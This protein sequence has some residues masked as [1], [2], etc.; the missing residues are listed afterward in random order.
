[1][2]WIKKT[3]SRQKKLKPW[4]KFWYDRK[5]QWPTA[6]TSLTVNAVNLAEAGQSKYRVNNG[7]KRLKLY[8]GKT[9]TSLLSSAEAP[10]G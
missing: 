8:Q 9:A 1:M 3:E 7:L 10:A 2:K 5:T 6:Y 4:L